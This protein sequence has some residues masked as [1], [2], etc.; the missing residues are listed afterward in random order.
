MDPGPISGR[1]DHGLLWW[2]EKTL[3]IVTPRNIADSS[4]L[5][6]Y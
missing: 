1:L 4:G 6:L 3:T 5:T 2:A